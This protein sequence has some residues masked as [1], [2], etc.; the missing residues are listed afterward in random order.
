MGLNARSHFPMFEVPEA[1]AAA[2]ERFV[3]KDSHDLIP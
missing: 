3:N 2:I 1:M